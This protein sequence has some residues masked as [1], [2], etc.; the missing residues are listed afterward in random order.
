MILLCNGA[1][2]PPSEEVKKQVDSCDAE[3]SMVIN[4]FQSN[5]FQINDERMSSRCDIRVFIYF[6]DVLLSRPDERI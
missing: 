6:F 4:R 2:R 1:P 3:R 5:R